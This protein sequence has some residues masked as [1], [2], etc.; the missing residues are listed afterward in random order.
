MSRMRGLGGLGSWRGCCWGEGGNAEVGMR[1]SECGMRSG[2]W[3]DGRVGFHRRGRPCSF[4]RWLGMGK[5][6]GGKWRDLGWTGGGGW[7]Y[8]SAAQ[9]D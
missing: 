7:V 2:E 6:Q 8:V 3:D 5:R 9:N 1:K 4:R